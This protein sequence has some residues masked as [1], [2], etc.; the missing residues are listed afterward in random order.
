[1]SGF[2]II[3]YPVFLTSRITPMP[4][5]LKPTPRKTRIVLF[6]YGGGMRG[7]VASHILARIE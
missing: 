5:P 6:V 4:K 3:G 1:M 2:P 7:I